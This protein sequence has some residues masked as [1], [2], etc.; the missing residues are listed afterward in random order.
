MAKLREQAEPDFVVD[1]TPLTKQQEEAISAFIR[2][3][4]L[5]TN[6]KKSKS[7]PPEKVKN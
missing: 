2:Q 1:P 3:H 7:S 5:R 4:K 6:G